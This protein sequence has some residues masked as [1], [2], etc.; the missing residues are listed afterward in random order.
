MITAPI[1][2]SCLIDDDK[3]YL[4]GMKKLIQKYQLSKAIIE[5]ANGLE[6]LEYFKN[7]LAEE[8]KLP[9]VILLDINMPIMDGWRFMEMFATIKPN[10][11]K[12]ITVY[13]LSSSINEHDIQRAKAINDVTDYIVKPVSA[14]QLQEIFALAA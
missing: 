11:G 5:F 2:L 12:K 9:E 6:A 3:I 1:N 14:H 4:F 8:E 13:M 10:I 7:V